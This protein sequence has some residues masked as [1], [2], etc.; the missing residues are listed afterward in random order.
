M[1]YPDMVKKSGSFHNLPNIKGHR[2]MAQKHTQEEGTIVIG[3]TIEVEALFK[4][5]SLFIVKMLLLAEVF[6]PRLGRTSE[7]T[8][9]AQSHQ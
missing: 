2:F 9:K 1:N 4:K 8:L 7:Y 3:N 5:N 6:M